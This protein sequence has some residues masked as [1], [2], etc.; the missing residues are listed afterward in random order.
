MFRKHEDDSATPGHGSCDL[1]HDWDPRDE[2]PRVPAE[3]VG[4][5]ARLQGREEI[6]KHKVAHFIVGTDKGVVHEPIVCEGE[7]SLLI[8]FAID[9]LEVLDVISVRHG[10]QNLLDASGAPMTCT[11]T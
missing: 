2:I 1:F 3:P 11:Y 10:P 9:I 4:G 8:K 6:L 5:G 7:F